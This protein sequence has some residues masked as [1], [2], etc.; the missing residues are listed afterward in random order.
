MKLKLMC[1]LEAQLD[2]E[3]KINSITLKLFFIIT[4]PARYE[5]ACLY[6]TYFYIRSFNYGGSRVLG[7]ILFLLLDMV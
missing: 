6:F 4:A 5:Y 7:T 1:R 2:P 3:A